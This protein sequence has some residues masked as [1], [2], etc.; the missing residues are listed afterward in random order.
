MAARLLH[1]EAAPLGAWV[2]ALE[3]HAALDVNG[4]HLQRVDVGAV[5]VLGIG[6]RRLEQLADQRRALLR[7]EGE[8]VHRLVDGLAAD[9]VGDQ[10]ALLGRDARTAQ[11]GFGFHHFF[12][13]AG[14]AAAAA[15]GAAAAG[16][17]AAP[18]APGGPR[19]SPPTASSV[20]LPTAE[21]LLK[22]RV[23]ANSPSLW[24]T[25]FS[26]TYTGTCCLPLCTAM[27]RPTKSGMIVERRDQVL[28]GRLSLVLRAFSTLASRW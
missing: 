13:G 4:L 10:A 9:H 25:M 20:R 28:I 23:S 1:P 27:V 21:W 15:A 14:A 11:A 22:M 18:G 24:P 17:A 7:R 3:E 19:R 8:D 2:K 26:V 12:P 6:D 5:V 16:A